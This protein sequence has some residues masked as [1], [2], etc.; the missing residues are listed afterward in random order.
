MRRVSLLAWRSGWMIEL[1]QIDACM[2]GRIGRY[3]VRAVKK[4]QMYL[5]LLM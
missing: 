4:G 2:A 3:R 1:I 5:S